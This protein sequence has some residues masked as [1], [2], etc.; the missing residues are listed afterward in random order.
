M[1]LEVV[2]VSYNTSSLLKDCLKSLIDCLQKENLFKNTKVSVVDNAS[3]DNSIAMVKKYFPFVCLTENKTNVGFA[4]ANNQAIRK[5]SAEYIFL[6][7]SD[8][9]VLPNA[10]SCLLDEIG[11]NEKI[12]AVG[13]KL[14]NSDR[15]LQ[16]S[17]GYSP[18]FFRV[19]CWM[20]FLDDIPILSRL[21]RPY[22]ASRKE[23]YQTYH[24]V[25]WVTGAALLFRNK[26]TKKVGFL[27]EKIFMY[28]EEVEWCHRIRKM[29]GKIIFL[30][31][32]RII[33][34]TGGSQKAPG[35]GIIREFQSIVYFY[36]K[37]RSILVLPVRILLKI[38]ALLR[39][40]LFGIIRQDS[41]KITLY[42]KAFQVA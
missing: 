40:I 18:T 11:K 13:P 9:I 15:S 27:D 35:T 39:L 22:Q 25:D 20:L 8:T 5:S 26:I 14:L 37:Y 2:I 21:I 17:F 16:Q 33:H 28:G 3:S 19:F 30:P 32:S 23:W 34:K 36:Q 12:W 7:N 29:G 41:P 24:E 4:A 31:S 42:A 6:L 38:G 10:V 1:K